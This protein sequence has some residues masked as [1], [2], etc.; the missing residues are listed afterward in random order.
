MFCLQNNGRPI[1]VVKISLKSLKVGMYITNP[2]LSLQFNPGMLLTDIEIKTEQQLERILSTKYTDAFIDT[3]KGLFFRANPQ[4]KFQVERLF[5]AFG[6]YQYYDATNSS[7]LDNILKSLGKAT[8]QYNAF[9]KYCQQFLAKIHE[10]KKIDVS[11]SHEFINTIIENDDATNNATLF[12]LNMRGHDEYTYTHCI[13]VALYATIFGK[14]LDLS[15]DNLFLLGISGLYHDI[16]KI[17]ISEKILKKPTTLTDAEF[18]EIKKHPAYSCE[19]LDKSGQISDGIARAILE[20]H[21]RNDGHGYPNKLRA[22]EI[23][24]AAALLSIIDSYDALCSDRY[25]KSAVHSHK[26]VSVLFNSKN[27]SYSPTLVEKFVKLIGIYPVGS[28]VVLNNGKKGIVISQGKSSLLRPSIRIILDENNR[29]CRPYDISLDEYTEANK[30]M[31][32]VDCL[33]NRQCRIHL[34]SHI[35]DCGIN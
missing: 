12:L 11:A 25:Y 26:A 23:S 18:K 8:N 4:K 20:H 35:K 2:G 29:H 17:K 22:E 7:S 6:E 21:E 33:S 31:R 5:H 27:S 3:E 1:M 9:L 34:A 13:N 10:N 19:I 14:Y 24:H 30:P 15:R 16:G 32:I 28:I